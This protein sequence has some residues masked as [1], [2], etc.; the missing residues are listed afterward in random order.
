MGVSA[1]NDRYPKHLNALV[2]EAMPLTLAS[3]QVSAFFVESCCDGAYSIDAE[4]VD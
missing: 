3:L 4:C 1:I 2:L